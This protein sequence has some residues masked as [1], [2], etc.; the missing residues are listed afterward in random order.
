MTIL[1]DAITQ[2][3]DASTRRTRDD[4]GRFS[5][6]VHLGCTGCD[7]TVINGV[8]CH[9]AGCPNQTFEC[10]GCDAVVERRGAYCADC[11]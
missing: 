4:D 6:R 11:Q 8:P 10:R 1:E 9:E 5:S 2:G 7:A 3:F